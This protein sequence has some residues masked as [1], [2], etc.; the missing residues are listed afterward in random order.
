MTFMFVVDLHA[1]TYHLPFLHN[2][3]L[4]THFYSSWHYL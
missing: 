3:D 1:D 2:P 4:R